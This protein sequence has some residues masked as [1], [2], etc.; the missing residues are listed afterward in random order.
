MKTIDFFVDDHAI[1]R[2]PFFAA[3]DQDAA[4]GFRLGVSGA[5]HVIDIAQHGVLGKRR[6]QVAENTPRRWSAGPRSTSWG[7]LPLRWEGLFDSLR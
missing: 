1:R 7:R 2:V 4:H 5:L 3:F 6:F